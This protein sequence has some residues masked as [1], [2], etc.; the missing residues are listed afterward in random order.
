MENDA[1]STGLWSVP[2]LIGY[3]NGASQDFV[4]RSQLIKVLAAVK[5]V[6]GQRLY[7]DPDNSMQIDRIIFNN[8][9]LYRTHRTALDRENPKWRTMAGIPRQYH[10]DQLSTKKFET[11]RA[12]SAAMTGT[13]YTNENLY[14]T[15]REMSGTQTYAATLPGPTSGGILRYVIGSRAYN[16]SLSD[17]PFAGT[18]RQMFSLETNFEV[19]ATRL[20]EEVTCV[21]DL[22]RVPDFCV[23]YVKYGVLQYMFEKEGET[24]DIPRARYCEARFDRGVRLYR[25]LVNAAEAEAVQEDLQKNG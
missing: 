22:L 23:L 6:T 3:I 11:D 25:R 15:L 24:Q 12:P 9:P 18:L 2:E 14:G 16:G 7:T 13:G 1:W 5:S 4:L 20:V 17:A 10:Q 21:T 8:R 19:M